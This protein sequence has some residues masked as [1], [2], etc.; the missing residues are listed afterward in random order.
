MNLAAFSLRN[1]PL[2]WLV[3]IMVIAWGVYNYN[4]ISRREDPKSKSLSRW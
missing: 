2:L 3:V 1:K 4:T